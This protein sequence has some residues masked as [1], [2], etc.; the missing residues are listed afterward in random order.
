MS[1]DTLANVKSRLGVTTSA[2]DA[3]LTLFQGS[4]DQWVADYLGHDPAGGSYTEYHPGNSAFVHLQNYPVASLTSVKVDPS[5]LFGADSVMPATSYVLH[6]ERGVIQSL[7]GPFIEA[8]AHW[9]LSQNDLAF[10][11]RSPRAVQVVYTVTTGNVPAD[12]REAYAQLIGH[13]Y[14]RVKTQSATGYVNVTQQVFGN[15]ATRFSPGDVTG[16]P[17][18]P[19]VLTLLAPYRTPNV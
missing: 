12:V 10:W 14:R 3:L 4:A 5:Y 13:W 2:D 6:A 11:M 16:L 1:L 17:V 18:P 7:C 8:A 9:G 15:T 19:D